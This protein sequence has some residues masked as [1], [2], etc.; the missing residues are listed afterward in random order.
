MDI[1]KNTEAMGKRIFEDLQ[2]INFIRTSTSPE[3][4]KAAEI[5][6]DEL[7][8]V[9]LEAVIEEFPVQ[10]ADIEKVSL[11]AAGKEWEIQGYR[12]SGSTPAEGL[13]APFAYVQ[14][15]TDVDLYDKKGMIVLVNNGKMNNTGLIASEFR[16]SFVEFCKSFLDVVCNRMCLRV[17]HQSPS[18][19]D[20]SKPTDILHHVRCCNCDI[21]IE[22]TTPDL[23][24]EVVISDICGSSLFSF[25]CLISL[26]EDKNLLLCGKLVRQHYGIP[27]RLTL[28]KVELDGNF[29]SLWEL[30]KSKLLYE[31]DSFINRI[32]LSPVNLLDGFLIFLTSFHLTSPPLHPSSGQFL[33]QSSLQLRCRLH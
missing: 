33:R 7:A 26:C 21:E 4:T 3:E 1:L 5:I 10:T 2:K 9:D 11:T 27:D 16:A 31:S 22:P 14:Q 23:L 13:T 18:S 29:N 8:K 20:R 25:L 32:N 24:D 6:R 17:R 15:G 12:R 30:C 19:K 28:L